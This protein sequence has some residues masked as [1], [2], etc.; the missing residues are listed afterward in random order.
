MSLSRPPFSTCFEFRHDPDQDSKRSMRDITGVLFKEGPQQVHKEALQ[1][2]NFYLSGVA[3]AFLKIE[4]VMHGS[5]EIKC[6]A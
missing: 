6:L 4:S 3:G 5:V 1:P 2:S